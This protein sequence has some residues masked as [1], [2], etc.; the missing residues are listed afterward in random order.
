M[1][2]QE[3]RA[4]ILAADDIKI[5][6]VKTPEWPAVDGMV[7]VRTLSG[8][9]RERYL[10]SIREVTTHP[11][12]QQSVKVLLEGSGSKLAVCA[13][14]NDKG[15]LLFTSEDVEALG[16]KS[17]SALNRVVDAAAD[18]NGLSEKAKAAAKNDLAGAPV[19]VA[20]LSIV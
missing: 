18:L 12:E 6:P 9:G 13:C 7:N 11:G 14:C 2:V 20:G 1:T 5:V 17:A 15:E 3:M 4:A 8:M 19:A 10:D 16:A